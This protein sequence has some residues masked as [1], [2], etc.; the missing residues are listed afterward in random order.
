MSLVIEDPKA[1]ARIHA[2]ATSRGLPPVEAIL[3]AIDALEEEE[4]DFPLTPEV[5]AALK[6]GAADIEAG[7]T[8]SG[9]A[10]MAA[11]K[12]ALGL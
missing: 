9:P 2:F 4:D 12:A 3:E 10:N 11:R 5:I 6:R 7:R 1:E 8:S